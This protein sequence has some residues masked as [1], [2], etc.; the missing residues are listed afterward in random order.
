[1]SWSYDLSPMTRSNGQ[2][3]RGWELEAG[4]NLFLLGLAMNLSL[5]KGEMVGNASRCFDRRSRDRSRRGGL[6][7]LDIGISLVTIGRRHVK[8]KR[9]GARE[10]LRV[11]TLTGWGLT[12]GVKNG[13]DEVNI[14]ERPTK[15]TK[16]TFFDKYF[17]ET[18]SS[19][20]KAR[21]RKHETSDKSSKKVDT[22][23]PNAC[24]ARSLRSDRA[25]AK[26]RS[27]RSHC[28]FVPLGWY[29]ATELE[30]KLGRYA[31]TERSF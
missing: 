28:A 2:C 26:A 1:M 25:R 17:F 23:Q 30:P 20:R 5:S 11:S 24:S 22:Q 15:K 29:V 4:S 6:A 10:V 18:D 7:H 3:R 27:R 16:K 31:A 9:F 21:R 12:V 19:L 13:Y 8:G 14:Q